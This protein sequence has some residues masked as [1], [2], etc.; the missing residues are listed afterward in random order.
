MLE[1]RGLGQQYTTGRFQPGA[2]DAEIER[3]AGTPLSDT[4]PIQVHSYGQESNL[5]MRA[6]ASGS[7]R[8]GSALAQHPDLIHGESDAP[9]SINRGT[10]PDLVTNQMANL[11]QTTESPN[12]FS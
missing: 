3:R 10:E 5:G 9:V 7:A 2:D 1:S 8:S 12:V 11:G 4:G 6:D